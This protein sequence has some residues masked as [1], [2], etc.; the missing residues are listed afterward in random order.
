MGEALSFSQLDGLL[1]DH[2]PFLV[3]LS[4]GLEETLRV[5][6]AKAAVGVPDTKLPDLSGLDA[7]T[8]EALSGILSGSSPIEPDANASFELCFED[9]ILYLVKNESYSDCSPEDHWSGRYLRVYD[10]SHLL[11]SLPDMTIAQRFGDGGWFPGPWGH[12]GICAQR[13][14]IDIITHV[15]PVIKKST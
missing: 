9:Y 11:D 15:P 8:A 7:R 3:S 2:A 14:I 10:R 5:V 4:D 6:I 1:G 13:Q 12:Y